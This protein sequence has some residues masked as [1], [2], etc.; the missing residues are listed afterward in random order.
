MAPLQ[1]LPIG[2]N[3]SK[4]TRDIERW[5]VAISPTAICLI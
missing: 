2:M 3:F 5:V 4:E 1:N